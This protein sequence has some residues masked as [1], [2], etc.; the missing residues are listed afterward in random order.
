MSFQI[1][2][3]DDKHA[4]S[5]YVGS[6]RHNADLI[7]IF[8]GMDGTLYGV[9]GPVQS[10]PSDFLTVFLVEEIFQRLSA[11]KGTDEVYLDPSVLDAWNASRP[12]EGKV[13]TDLP[14]R[15]L[16][17]PRGRKTRRYVPPSR[18]PPSQSLEY[19]FSMIYSFIDELSTWPEVPPS[20]IKQ[21]RNQT[22]RLVQLLESIVEQS[23]HKSFD[24]K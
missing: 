11:S 17:P 22:T 23:E 15:L 18:I 8:L 9:S 2:R 10:H 12:E 19:R 24:S 3:R 6:V 5:R 13:L 7:N 14:Q 4:R 20:Q 1:A 21:A 16:E